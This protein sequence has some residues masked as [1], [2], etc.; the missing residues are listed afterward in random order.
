MTGKVLENKTAGVI[1]LI[2]PFAL[3]IV[4]I[5]IAWPLL[6]ATIALAIVVKVWQKYQWQ[7]WSQKINPFFN[8]LIR[9][10]RVA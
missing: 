6:L 8:E 7:R 4:L 3:S 1:V 10:T 2:I 5:Y 9:E